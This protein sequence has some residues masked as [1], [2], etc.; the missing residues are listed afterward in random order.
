MADK[1]KIIRHYQ[2]G[3][4]RHRVIETHLTLEQAQEHCR[5]PETSSRT[6]TSYRARERTRRLGPWFD[7]YERA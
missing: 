3:H 5:S 4:F 7:G 2:R 1:Y 6:A